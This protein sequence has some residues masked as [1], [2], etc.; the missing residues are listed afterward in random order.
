MSYVLL[1]REIM[2]D[3]IKIPHN[4]HFILKSTFHFIK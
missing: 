1:L 3:L 2:D 4:L